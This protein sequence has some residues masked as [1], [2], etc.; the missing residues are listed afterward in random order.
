LNEFY[1]CY[2]GDTVR[3]GV[4]GWGGGLDCAVKCKSQKTHI[5]TY[6]KFYLDVHYV[7]Y[8]C[9]YLYCKRLCALGSNPSNYTC[10]F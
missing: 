7:F 5:K 9:S 10:Q 1:Y 4:G 6:H 3:R 8:M 2:I